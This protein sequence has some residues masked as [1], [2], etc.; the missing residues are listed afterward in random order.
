MAMESYMKGVAKEY[1]KPVQPVQ[2]VKQ[3]QP[4]KQAELT[5]EP[6]PTQT[7]DGQD[8]ETLVALMNGGKEKDPAQSTIDTAI[9]GMN[10]QMAKMAKTRCAYAYDEGTKRITIKVYDDETDE[11]IREVPPEKSLE[12]LKKIWELAGIFIDEKR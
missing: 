10:A 1:E 12:A 3:T 7:T 6:V 2:P 11:L 5:I 8:I 9:S 4:V